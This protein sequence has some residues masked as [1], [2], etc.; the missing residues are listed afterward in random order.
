[1]TPSVWVV[2]NSTNEHDKRMLSKDQL[3][4]P[5][6]DEGSCEGK[7]SGGGGS[8][9]RK[10][11]TPGEDEILVEYVKK[12]GK[13]SW[14]DVQKQTGLSRSGGSC[15]L[16]WTTHLDPDLNKGPITEAEGKKIIELHA[17][18]GN[19]WS[20]IGKRVNGRTGD[21]IRNWMNRNNR[22]KGIGGSNENQRQTIGGFSM[23]PVPFGHDAFPGPDNL[24]IPSFQCP[25]GSLFIPYGHPPQETAPMQS[26]SSS[27][28]NCNSLLDFLNNFSSDELSNSFGTS[29]PNGQESIQPS[30]E[31]V[32]A[33]NVV[34]MEMN[35]APGTGFSRPDAQLES[36]P[37][38]EN[39]NDADMNALVAPGGDDFR[40]GG[41]NQEPAGASPPLNSQGC[42]IASY[43]RN[44]MPPGGDDL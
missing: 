27:P 4:L 14:S 25:N 15:R 12:H 6:T 26:E 17:T 36:E 23:N 13:G 28:G 16:R 40:S 7:T 32:P 20:L 24:G 8:G 3:D 2:S 37:T 44:S 43:P 41:H 10:R 38:Q 21:D 39:N 22:M 19:K 33:A 35:P 30:A 1:M 29:T 31:N 34:Q 9:S 42:D 11:W 18:W 5:S